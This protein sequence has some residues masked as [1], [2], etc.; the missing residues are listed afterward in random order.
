MY[1]FKAQVLW[2]VIGLEN[3]VHSREDAILLLRFR[4]NFRKVGILPDGL[5]FEQ[6]V[7]FVDKP[8]KRNFVQKCHT[9]ELVQT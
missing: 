7:E 9:F 6:F 8:F 1:I 5:E 4:D 3:G 2:C